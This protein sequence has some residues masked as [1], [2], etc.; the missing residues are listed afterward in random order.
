MKYCTIQLSPR[1]SLFSFYVGAGVPPCT[2]LVERRRLSRVRIDKYRASSKP[3]LLLTLFLK[4]ALRRMNAVSSSS[5]NTSASSQACRARLLSEASINSFVPFPKP[6]HVEKPTVRTSK[7]GRSKRIKSARVVFCLDS[8]SINEGGSG[9]CCRL[10]QPPG[11]CRVDNGD[12]HHDRLR[13]ELF[14]FVACAEK[15]RCCDDVHSVLPLTST[16]ASGESGGVCVCVCVFLFSIDRV[17][18]LTN[19]K[20]SAGKKTPSAPRP[21]T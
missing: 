6:P 3:R 18:R 16:G 19:E 21:R 1:L 17:N 14:E 15:T 2:N 12:V 11:C 20:S 13:R 7:E 9:F 10:F 8:C 5:S 4:W